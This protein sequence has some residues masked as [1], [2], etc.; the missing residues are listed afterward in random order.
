ML[1]PALQRAASAAAAAMLTAFLSKHLF[2][3]T[4]SVP[5]RTHPTK[6]NDPLA[7]Q[8]LFPL[9]HSPRLPIFKPHPIVKPHPKH[10]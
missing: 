9:L 6:V 5:N 3:Q 8:A 10:I 2:E 7:W 1:L 4:F